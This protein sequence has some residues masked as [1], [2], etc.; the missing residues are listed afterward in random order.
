MRQHH[1]KDDL[2]ADLK[3]LAEVFEAEDREDRRK[4]AERRL[5]GLP[6]P[7]RDIKTFDGFADGGAAPR[8]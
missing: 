1:P 8:D 2:Q 7:A 5:K 3:A 6:E 4:D